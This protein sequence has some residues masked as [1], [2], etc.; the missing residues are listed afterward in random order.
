MFR[1]MAN[2]T[3]RPT[4]NPTAEQRRGAAARWIEWAASHGLTERQASAG[5]YVVKTMPDPTAIKDF[6]S[7][8]KM[9]GARLYNPR[10]AR[11]R[12]A[13]RRYVVVQVLGRGKY[14][15]ISRHSTQALARAAGQALAD[16]TRRKTAVILASHLA[17]HGGRQ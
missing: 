14:K 10:P 3:R 12:A 11:K 2:P 8:A 15:P 16:R 13:T 17:M 5:L 9:L 6:S 1:R 7:L 4:K